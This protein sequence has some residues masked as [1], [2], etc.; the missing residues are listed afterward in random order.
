MCA[1]KAINQNS[2]PE[3]LRPVIDGKDTT[4]VIIQNGVGNEEPFRE[5]F[6]EN[7]ILTCVAC[8]TPTPEVREMVTDNGQTWVGASQAV[9]GIV[10]HTKSEHTQIGLYRNPQLDE[11]QEH[12][13]LE[14]FTA[15]LSAGNT[16]FDVEENMQIK[17]WEKVVWNAAW[18]SLTTLT[19]LD[20]QSWLKSSPR[21][22]PM[23]RQ[24][25]REVI[26]VAQKCD[27]PLQYDLIDQ[28]IGKILAMPGIG[29]SM[30]ADFKAGR[31]ME[32]EIILGHP[33]RKAHELQVPTPV[34]DTL[35]TL[36]TAVNSRL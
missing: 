26:D 36:L 5:A 23:T 2:V 29:S 9:P 17:R 27:V 24:L 20:T 21:A 10:K 25:M 19:L 35:Y 16:P 33:V 15:L 34:L 3:K 30:Q 12:K 32:V 11:K 1:N 18:N 14:R 4:L 31:R 8:F 7:T 13:R 6:P 28:L 22:M